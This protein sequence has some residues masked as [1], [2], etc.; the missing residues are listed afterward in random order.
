MS[1]SSWEAVTEALFIPLFILGVPLFD[2][3]FA[4][5]RRRRDFASVMQ[6]VAD[7]YDIAVAGSSAGRARQVLGPQAAAP[8]PQRTQVVTPPP[9][10]PASLPDPFGLRRD[11][12]EAVQHLA[13]WEVR[14]VKPDVRITLGH[15]L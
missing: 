13:A 5:V 7:H 11:G 6:F 8:A 14:D 1:F 9:E 15:D 12:G 2:M 4:I 3:T 10:R